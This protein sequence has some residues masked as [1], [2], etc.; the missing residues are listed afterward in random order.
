MCLMMK[1]LVDIVGGGLG[2]WMEVGDGYCK[3][4]R[5]IKGGID[6]FDLMKCL[7]GEVEGPGGGRRES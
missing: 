6:Y 4:L 7:E 2:F 5:G 3:R 1:S